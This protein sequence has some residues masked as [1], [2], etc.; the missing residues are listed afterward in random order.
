MSHSTEPEKTSRLFGRLSLCMPLV[1]VTYLGILLIG[2]GS[3]GFGGWRDL[4][5]LLGM[6]LASAVV[7]IVLSVISF[8]REERSVANGFALFIHISFLILAGQA[9]LQ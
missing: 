5:V 7:G 8:R 4:V 6:M 2:G 9:F 1:P 3:S